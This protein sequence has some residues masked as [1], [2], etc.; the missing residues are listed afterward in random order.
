MSLVLRGGAVHNDNSNAANGIHTSCI[1]G[2]SAPVGSGVYTDTPNFDATNNWWGAADGPSEAGGGSG[3][4][5]DD[6]VLFTPFI[7]TGCPH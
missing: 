1:S 3:D 2:N 5:V 7:T 4:G 6:Y